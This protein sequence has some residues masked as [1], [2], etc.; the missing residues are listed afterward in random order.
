MTLD[1]VLLVIAM[2]L[3]LL[4][5]FG[6]GGTRFHLGWLGAALVILTLVV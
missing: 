5:A 1:K 3:M 2:V 6:V 4:H